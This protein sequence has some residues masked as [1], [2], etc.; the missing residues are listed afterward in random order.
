MALIPVLSVVIVQVHLVVK[1]S[2]LSLVFKLTFPKLDLAARL[3]LYLYL[4]KLD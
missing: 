1:P 2:C 4:A 3:H